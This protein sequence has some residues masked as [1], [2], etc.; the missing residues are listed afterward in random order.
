MGCCFVFFFQAEDG[1]RDSSVTGVQTCA[2]P[3]LVEVHQADV[4]EGGAIVYDVDGMKPEPGKIR[5]NVRLIG[6]PLRKKAQSLSTNALMRNTVALGAAVRLFDMDF[7]HVESAFKDIWGDKKPEVV[8][9]N[10]QAAKL[11]ADAVVETGG[12]LNYG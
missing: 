2:L 9:Q 7:R 11:G 10:I 3:I 8:Q 4:L 5:K 1:I 6:I 12:S